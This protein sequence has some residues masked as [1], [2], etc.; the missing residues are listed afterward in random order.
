MM[1][2]RLPFHRDRHP[3]VRTTRASASRS[4]GCAGGTAV[5]AAARHHGAPLAVPPLRPAIEA[6]LPEEAAAAAATASGADACAAG[7]AAA[8]FITGLL[9]ACTYGWTDTRCV[10]LHASGKCDTLRYFHRSTQTGGCA[11]ARR[12]THRRRPAQDE[13]KR[14]W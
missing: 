10:R 2:T 9:N 3:S 7:P 5:P 4:P 1:V 11:T 13:R 6:L 8:A 14:T 12:R